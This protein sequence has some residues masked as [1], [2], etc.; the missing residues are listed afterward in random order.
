MIKNLKRKFYNLLYSLPFGMKGADEEIFG[1]KDSSSSDNVGVH[2]VIN[3]NRLSKNLLKGEVTQQVEELRYRNYQVYKESS[4]YKYLGDGVAIKKED[5]VSFDINNFHIIQ[6]NKQICNS[7]G[8]EM[9]RVDTKDYSI[10]EYTLNIVYDSFPRFKL[11]KYCRYFEVSSNDN[12]Y[13]IILRFINAPNKDDISSYSFINELKR[14]FEHFARENDYNR[15]KML[16]FVTYK[17][18]GDEELVRYTFNDLTL[19]DMSLSSDGKEYIIRYKARF[20]NRE[21]LTTKF[22]SKSMD[23]KYKNNEK[24]ELSLDLS[25]TERVKYCCQCGKPINV[26]DGDITEETFGYALCKECLEKTLLLENNFYNLN[27]E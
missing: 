6:E 18:L 24:K 25:N 12:S 1:Q 11:E 2:Q 27:K 7:I 13:D 5:I 10:D 9:K 20:L 23:E 15:L 17:C 19:V 4:K 26:Y 22:Y 16:D 21:D 14:I 8:D 3:E